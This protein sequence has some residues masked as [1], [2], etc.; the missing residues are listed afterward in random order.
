MR[1][2]KIPAEL[3]VLIGSA[4]LFIPF[5]GT[6]HLFDWDEINFAEASREMLAT[7]NFIIP[8]I[9]FAPF[10]EKPPLFFWLQV[11]SMKA[12]GVNEFAA[13][14]PNAVCGIVTLLLFFRLGKQMVNQQFGL[15]WVLVY[16]GSMLPHLYFKSGIIDPWFNLF[17]FLSIYQLSNYSNTENRNS[18]KAVLLAG[19]FAGLAVMTKGPVAVLIVGLC[20]GVYAIIN[21][22][23]NLMRLKHL[24]LFLLVAAMVGGIWFMALLLK[25]QQQI[26]F[27]FIAYQVR[28]FKTEDA[29]HG[30]PFFYHFIVLLIGCFPAAA[31]SILSMRVQKSNAVVPAHFHRWMLILFWVVLILFSIVKTKIVHYSSLCYFP[32]SFLAA[33]SFYS[34]YTGKRTLPVWNKWLQFATGLLLSILFISVSFIDKLKPWLLAQGRIDD[35]FARANLQANVSWSGIEVLPGFM[36]LASLLYFI[37]Q[38]R[39]NIRAALIALFATT[40]I[41]FNL[42][43]VLITPKIEPYTQGAAIEFYESK[44]AENAIVEPVGFFSYAHLFYAKRPAY[45]GNTVADS[46]IRYNTQPNV[47]VYFVAKVQNEKEIAIQHPGCQKLYSKNGFVFFKLKR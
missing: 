43:I 31:L 7:G 21:R 42:L 20:Y 27:Q 33:T 8:Q 15:I 29:G 6:T 46:I 23:K 41:A 18:T 34:L 2:N 40:T 4:I 37:F 36:M 44:A 10:W 39:R 38:T 1:L 12:F 25:G 14:F 3:F 16:I 13:R 22:F 30:G 24:L 32:L 45:L 5:L 9:N 28:L 26:I 19:L 11:L 35:E 47:P 17:I